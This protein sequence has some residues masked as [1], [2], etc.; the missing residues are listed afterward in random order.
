MHTTPTTL[1]RT[2]I[3]QGSAFEYELWLTVLGSEPAFL[4]YAKYILDSA[5][6]TRLIVSERIRQQLLRLKNGTDRLAKDGRV[7][8]LASSGLDEALVVNA[9]HLPDLRMDLLEHFHRHGSAPVTVW[10]D[11]PQADYCQ[12]RLTIDGPGSVCGAFRSYSDSTVPSNPAQ[13]DQTE[14]PRKIPI[15]VFLGKAACKALSRL[16]VQTFDEL[17]ELLRDEGET[18]F[19]RVDWVRTHA[20]QL[21]QDPLERLLLIVER[22]GQTYADSVS[23][24]LKNCTIHPTARLSGPLIIGRNVHIGADA[25]IIGPAA[26]GDNA[27]IGTE[28]VITRSIVLPDTIIRNGR[29][30]YRC[31]LKGRSG[32]IVYESPRSVTSHASSSTSAQS[33]ITVQRTSW[34]KQCFDRLAAGLGLICISPILLVIAFAV[35]VTS[36]GP[37]LYRHRRQG[38]GGKEF[39]CLK[40]RTMIPGAESLQEKLREYNEVDGPQFKM[41]SDP[42]ITPI[43][44]FLRRTNLDE[45]PQLINVVRGEMSLVGP[46][47]SPDSENQLCPVWRKNRLSVLPGITGLWQVTRSPDR[48]LDFQEWIYYDLQY[49]KKQSFWLDVQILWQT[50]RTMVRRSPSKRWC[51]RWRPRLHGDLRPVCAEATGVQ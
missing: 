10:F 31:I 13:D 16:E 40:F 50:F 45:L 6:D 14:R 17:V 1:K 20:A 23:A 44:S 18:L 5:P 35:K 49:V 36:P 4:H 22:C 47:P 7:G 48:R 25:V 39:D 19:G 27:C 8:P 3:K 12:E 37:I 29:C 46:R 9:E 43:G 24:A 42:R 30:H 34:V 51:R 2:R 26:L 38:F 41:S 32:K 28:A 11:C 15:A 33:A 21:T